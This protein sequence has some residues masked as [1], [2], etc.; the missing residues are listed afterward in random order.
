MRKPLVFDCPSTNV[1]ML[2]HVELGCL[3]RDKALELMCQIV[4]PCGQDHVVSLSK[5]KYFD[6]HFEAEPS[7]Y[8]GHSA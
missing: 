7:R 6:R 3:T 2:C 4:C 5:A 8:E 1:A